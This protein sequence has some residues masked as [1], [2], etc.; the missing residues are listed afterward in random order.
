MRRHPAVAVAAEELTSW[1]GLGLGV[2]A[3][4][5]PGW[6]Q[7]WLL[8]E[9]P[10][11]L[12]RGRTA[13]RTA[14][15]L[16]QVG[17]KRTQPALHVRRHAPRRRAERLGHRRHLTRAAQRRRREPCALQVRVRVELARCDVVEL[18]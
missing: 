8:G 15:Q 2:R 11:L 12:H 17:G 9:Q 13:W 5:T 7:A 16:L 1:L 3:G 14:E 18:E 10:Q 4:S 6:T